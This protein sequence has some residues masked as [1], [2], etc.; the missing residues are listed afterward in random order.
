MKNEA[1]GNDF[2]SSAGK[3]GHEK[4]SGRGRGRRNFE[5]L[6]RACIQTYRALA[7]S[8]DFVLVDT[9][10]RSESNSRS[11]SACINTTEIAKYLPVQMQSLEARRGTHSEQ[12]R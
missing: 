10:I 11:M 1:A 12:V 2:S 4:N 5:L 7:R 8:H 6:K 9:V 3:T